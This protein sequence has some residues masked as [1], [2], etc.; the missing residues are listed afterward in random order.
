MNNTTALIKKEV[1]VSG[2]DINYRMKSM[3]YLGN[4][5]KHLPFIF[6]TVLQCQATIG[7]TNPVLFDA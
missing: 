3:R 1:S 2:D 5:T 4:K 6:E 7:I